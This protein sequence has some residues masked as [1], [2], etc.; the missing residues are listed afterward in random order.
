M[1]SRL[2]NLLPRVLRRT[3][4][5][6]ALLLALAPLSAARHSP[7]ARLSSASGGL[8]ASPLESDASAPARARVRRHLAERGKGTYIGDLLAGRDSA[9][10]RW[11]DRN[12]RPITVWIQPSSRERGWRADLPMQVRDAFRE[13]D[14]LRLP[15]HFAFTSDSAR[16]DV[17]VAFIDRF[18]EPISG[19]TRWV[20]DEDWWIT[21]ADI[22]LALHHRNGASLDADAMRAMT[23]HEIGHLLGL[24]HTADVASIMAPKVRVRALSST[25]RA[26]VRL[27]Y[28]LPPG[29][30]R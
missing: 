22:V 23:L 1:I 25:D 9:L 14:A 27:L 4:H 29:G 26:T 19:R 7:R 21:D 8:V 30:I 3:G 17:R 11:P 5:A 20:R 2:A 15:V 16:A 12:G 28:A 13:W 10:A 24:D 18:A 6:T